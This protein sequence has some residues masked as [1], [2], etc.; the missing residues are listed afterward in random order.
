MKNNSINSNAY[1]YLLSFLGIGVKVVDAYVEG[2]WLR[3]DL[4]SGSRF[5]IKNENGPFPIIK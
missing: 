2:K 3:C 5:S 1:A 4:N